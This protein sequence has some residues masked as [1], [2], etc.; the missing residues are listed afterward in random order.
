MEEPEVRREPESGLL[1]PPEEVIRPRGDLLK[2]VTQASGV[3]AGACFACKKCSAGCPLQYA[4][5]LHPYQV[6][7]CVQLGLMEPLLDC[8]TIWICASCQTCLTRCPNAVDLPRLMDHLKT[9]VIAR[10][11]KAAQER[12]RLF[13]QFFLDGVR[14]RG[15]VFE[16]SLMGRY[17]MATGGAFGPEAL[18]NARLGL[19]MFKRGRLKLIPSR[20]RDR[21][22][23]REV[24]D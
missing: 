7:R 8:R 5:D 17:L 20:V 14:K 10:G 23:L 22:W 1:P 19:E 11:G 4:M 6:V 12:V 21:A 9:L 16:G 18:K 15:R 2:Q 24:F 13:H 3:Q